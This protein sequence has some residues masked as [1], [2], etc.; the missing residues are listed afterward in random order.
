MPPRIVSAAR[1]KTT[2][3]SPAK[4]AMEPGS[5]LKPALQKLIAE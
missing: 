1:M 5:T 2:Q 4:T 3:G